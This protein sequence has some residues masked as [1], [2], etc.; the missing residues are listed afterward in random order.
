MDKNSNK[1]IWYISKYA[2]TPNFGAPSR[3]YFYSKYLAKKRSVTL[4][5][6]RSNGGSNLPRLGFKNHFTDEQDGVKTVMLNGP[7]V[8]YG[9]NLRRI[10]SWALFEFRLLLWCL[11]K[12]KPRPDVI[13]VSSLSILTF[14]S[15]ILLKRFYKCK[16]ICEVRDIWPL[17]IQETK[18]WTDRNIFIRVL[19]AIELSGYKNADAI[20]GSM[21][22]L[23][24]HIKERGIKDLEK[25]HYLPMGFDTEWW[26]KSDQESVVIDGIINQIPKEHTLVGYAGTIGLVNAIGQ[27]IDAAELLRDKPISFLIL[28]DG[29]LKTALMEDVEKRGLE[30]VYFLPRVPKEEVQSFLSKCHILVNP[31]LADVTIYKYGVSPNK[32]IDYMYSGRPIIVP[33]DGYHNIINEAKCGEFIKADD[34]LVLSKTIEKYSLM[35]RE[36]LDEIGANGRR[37]LLE[38]L[39]YNTLAN[40]YLEIIDGL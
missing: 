29:G 8:Q 5:Y 4:V 22:N 17:T 34:S 7:K 18:N 20:V 30:N 37:F 33:M 35:P 31:W 14:L 24:E 26:N 9:F 1:E 11:I 23:K 13:I 32:W 38:N 10:F 6:S 25:V 3:Q 27:I 36:E 2:S 15:G 19:G 12:K 40:K 39:S 21:A 28:G 16:L